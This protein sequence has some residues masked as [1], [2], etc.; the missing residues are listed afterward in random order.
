[1]TIQLNAHR[2]NRYNMAIAVLAGLS[3]ICASNLSW[4]FWGLD[5]SSS[6]P[7]WLRL[8]LLSAIILFAIPP[9]ANR[10]GPLIEQVLSL[11]SNTGFTLLYF[12]GLLLALFVFIYLST[13]NYFQGDGYN[14]MGHLIGGH[15][16]SPTE[17]LDYLVHFAVSALLGGGEI[18]VLR[19]YQICSYLAGAVFITGIFFYFRNKREII[20]AISIAGA[21]GIMQFFFGYVES[22]TFRFLFMFFYL[23]S[24]TGDFE[25]KTVSGATITYFI[26]SIA[27]HLSSIVLI[28]SFVGL[29]INAYRTKKVIA[30]TISLAVLLCLIAASAII[31]FAPINLRDILIPILAKPQNPYFLISIAHLKDLLNSFLIS[32]PLIVLLF[33]KSPNTGGSS[34]IWKGLIFVPPLLFMILV[35]PKI[36]AFRDPARS[37]GFLGCSSSVAPTRRPYQAAPALSLGLWAA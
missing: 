16:F 3:I 8:F 30:A 5:L 7:F 18:G 4:G 9:M 22:Y 14:V 11:I 20:I 28:P 37:I 33:L 29:I 32:S 35:D 36:G 23:L 2:L 31:F 26:F 25:K 12:S 24:A 34:M 1:M 13:N 15:L 19:S 6:L 17:P 21:F 27:F 10:T